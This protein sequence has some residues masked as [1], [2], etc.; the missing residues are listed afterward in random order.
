MKVIF[1]GLLVMCGVVVFPAYAQSTAQFGYQLHPEKLL[2]NTEGTLQIFVTSNDMMI[3]RTVDNLKVISS[4]NSVIQIISVQENNIGYTKNVQI[5][6]IKPGIANIAL[7]APGFTSKEITLEVFNNNNYPTQILMKVTPNDFPIDGPRFGYVSVE[8]AT[9]SGLPTVATEDIMIKIETP[10]NDIINIRNSEMVIK[11]GEYFAVSEFDIEN[12]GDAIIFASA[13]NMK[14]ISQFIHVRKAT[15]PLQV[16]LFVIPERYNS[17]SG[18]KG[19]A[20]VQLLDGSGFPVIAEEDIALKLGVENP[21]VSMNTSHDFEEIQFSSKELVIKKGEYSAY[22]TFTPRPNLGKFIDTNEQTL[23][24]YVSTNNYLTKGSSIVITHDD[25]GSLEGE[26]PSVTTVLPF[27]TTGKKEIIAVTYFETDIE[28]S[29]KTGSSTLGTSERELVSV[30]VP[31]MAKKDYEINFASSKSNTV[32]PINPIMKKG[33]NAVLVF[34]NTGTVSS[35]V[36]ISFYVT[37]TSGVKSLTA[38]SIGPI[39]DDLTLIVE[40]I[41]PKILAEHEFPVLAYLLE[42]EEVE[43]G[44]TTSTIDEEEDEDG[45]I[46]VTTF[47][48]DAVLTL[49]ANNFVDA[50][51]QIIKKNQPYV[52][53]DLKSKE[54]GTTSLSFQA[55]QFGGTMSMTSTTTDPANI[56]MSFAKNLLTNTESLATIQLLD[57]VGNPVYAK[58]DVLI[59]IVSNNESV[60]K[61][62]ENVIIKKGEYFS[63]IK[64][65]S[66]NEGLI[67]VALLSEDLP[68]SKYE[69]N[70]VDVS[71]VV[72]IE[73]IGGMNWNERIEAKLS[74]AIPQID[75]ALD[76]FNVEWTILGGEILKIEN[77]TNNNGVASAHV[78]ANDQD[79][80]SISATVS[81]NG[82]SSSSINTHAEILN[83]PLAVTVE[84]KQWYEFNESYMIIIAIPLSI[85]GALFVLN[86]IGRLDAITEKLGI[87]EKFEEIKEKIS[88]IRN[89]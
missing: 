46:G 65:E 86:R 59:K 16:Q 88:N 14:K 76:G 12:S 43:E 8:L 53:F 18:G 34:G 24:M 2:E 64:L 89:R 47:I 33:Q 11:K 61:I 60:L 32:N 50:E 39:S 35:K 25:V 52:L 58:K 79:S 27:L 13:D 63:T 84:Q 54:I 30:T 40:P 85:V 29:R 87:G 45:R 22:T 62:P 4:D 77:I 80:V 69:L 1:L 72:S 51:P 42:S 75:T 56:H 73:L 26:G 36:P 37:D 9:T 21:D 15:D 6:A 74:V 31:V 81:G 10:N 19:Y 44:T 48:E 66:K 83:K 78:L 20:I 41:V 82:F 3:P 68:L 38:N 28:V 23:N 57:S 55:G 7:A 70:I 5:K 67:E 71:P 49:S 17:F